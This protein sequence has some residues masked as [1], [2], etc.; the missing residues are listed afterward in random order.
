M[1]NSHSITSY[2]GVDV[3]KAKLDVGLGRPKT[4]LNQTSAIDRFLRALPA[5]AHVVCEATGG[6][7]RLLVAACHEQQRPVSVVNPLRV[8]RFAEAMGELAKTD[9]VDAGMIGEYACSKRPAPQPPPDPIRIE[10]AEL[11]SAR[12]NLIAR[13]VELASLLEHAQ[14]KLVLGFYRAEDKTLRERIQK[15]DKRIRQLTEASPALHARDQVQQSFAGVGAVT[16][17]VLLAHLPELG[18]LNNSQVS[19]L[20]GLAPRNNDSGAHAGRRFIKGG[21][22]RVR[23]AIYMATLSAIRAKDSKLR[24]FYLRLRQAGK[25]AKVAL[26]AAA[27]KLL[28]WINAALRT[29]LQ[30]TPQPPFCPGKKLTTTS[31]ENPVAELKKETE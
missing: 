26:V 22:K 21:R 10:L 16:S 17:A 18:S 1:S 19:A 8:R 2:I 6:Y 25:P 11:I 4:I 12:D 28:I 29:A 9:P 14:A 30:S 5:G 13:R 7:E 27:R 15:L 24:P 20:S 3:A 31:S 23:D